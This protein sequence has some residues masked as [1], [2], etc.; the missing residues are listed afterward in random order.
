MQVVSHDAEVMAG[1]VRFV[2]IVDAQ[3]SLCTDVDSQCCTS[4]D[5]DLSCLVVTAPFEAK[6]R[7]QSSI[8]PSHSVV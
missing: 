3:L 2:Y 4:T 1:T 5:P 6:T 8:R 7:K